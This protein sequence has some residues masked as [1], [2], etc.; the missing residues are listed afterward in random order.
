[1]QL[2]TLKLMYLLFTTPPTYEF[3]YTNDLRVL[4]D[5]L[6]RNLLDLPEYAAALRHTYLRV[7]YPLLEH[8]Q[9][10]YPPFYKRQEIRGLLALL[11]GDRVENT[12]GSPPV[13]PGWSHFEDVDETTKRLVKRCQTVSWLADPDAP[14]LTLVNSPTE[15]RTPE[16]DSPISPSKP[17]PPQLPAPRKLRKRTSSKASAPTTGQFLPPRLDAA[18]Q[19]SVSMA[20]MAQQKEKPGVITPSRNPSA[21]QGLLRQAMFAKKEKPPPPKARRSGFVR[22][23][24]HLA[25]TELEVTRLGVPEKTHTPVSQRNEAETYEDALEEQNEESQ[26]APV[27]PGQPDGP[28]KRAPTPTP[29]PPNH[30][31]SNPQTQPQPQPQSNTHTQQQQ[32]QQQP[33]KKPPPAPKARR[34]WRMRKSRDLDDDK[35]PGKF[36]TNLPSVRTTHVSALAPAPTPASNPFSTPA[37]A[38]GTTESTLF[39]PAAKEKTLDPLHTPTTPRAADVK[40]SVSEA[41]SQAQAQATLQVEECLENTHLGEQGRR[42]QEKEQGEPSNGSST[43]TVLHP[44]RTSSLQASQSQSQPQLQEQSGVGGPLEADS[45]SVQRTFVAPPGQAPIRGVPGP[46]V[47]VE[48]SPFVSDDEQGNEARPLRTKESWEDFEE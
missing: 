3:F 29:A 32:Q 17:K 1:L 6:V 11:C 31:P 4:V 28:A 30:E 34:G 46:R 43:G 10:K 9:L 33:P 25:S 37:P 36:S 21:K 26:Q 18:R 40:R 2:L 16:P 7:L 38:E 24:A 23:K 19:S 41:M 20:E 44:L 14:E 48:T 35:E 42:V 22:P 8:T 39:P 13:G 45:P 5:I 27:Q 15:D 47:D 12:N